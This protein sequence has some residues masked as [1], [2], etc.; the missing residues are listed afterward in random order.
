MVDAVGADRH[1]DVA[2][3]RGAAAPRRRRP[4]ARCCADGRRPAS[5]LAPGWRIR[6]RASPPAAVAAYVA[7]DCR[8]RHLSGAPRGDRRCASRTLDINV[9]MVIAVAGALALGEWLEAATRR[10]SLRAGAV[11][12]GADAGAGAAGDPRAARSGAARGARP[13]RRRRASAVPVDEIAVGDVVIVR[14]GRQDSVDGRSS[15][16]TATSTRRR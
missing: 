13:P 8:R 12:R 7:G 2:R 1:A 14:P 5:A 4:R 10:V 3:A 9:L 15:P 11:A 16:G 6:R